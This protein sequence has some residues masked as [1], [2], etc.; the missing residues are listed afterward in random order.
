MENLEEVWK[1]IPG[2]E[3]KY[4]ASTLGRIKSLSRIINSRNQNGAFSYK[5]KEQLLSPGKHDKCGH[6][7]VMLNAPR[8]CFTVHQLVMLTFYGPPPEGKV[9]CHTN[10]NAMDNRLCNLR[11]DTQSENVIDVFRQGKK[12]R[13]LSIDDVEAIR[14]GLYCGISCTELG[15]MFS[16]A[17]QTISKI[18]RGGTYSWL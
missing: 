13:S 5:S 11:Y 18:N 4:Q 10:G 2:Y 6:L 3:G 14:F 17:H 12:W 1:D 16:V 7:S 9:V 8:K 15:A